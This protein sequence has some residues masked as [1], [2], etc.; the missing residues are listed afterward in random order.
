MDKPAVSKEQATVHLC[1]ASQPFLMMRSHLSSVAG[2]LC[3]C[4]VVFL[5][6]ICGSKFCQQ[7][8]QPVI[9]KKRRYFMMSLIEIIRIHKTI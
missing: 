9:Q 5:S 2:P 4:C 6:Q 8:A 3:A 1:P 7:E